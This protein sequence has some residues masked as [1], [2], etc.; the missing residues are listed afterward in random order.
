ML[1][2]RITEPDGETHP[3][4][5]RD[6]I[7]ATLN[8]T[9]R[10]AGAAGWA[11]LGA[12]AIL[13]GWPAAE[14]LSLQGLEVEWTIGP[15]E[16]GVLFLF[17]GLLY[18]G[19]LGI[20]L[21]RRGHADWRRAAGFALLAMFWFAFGWNAG[22]IIL[23]GNFELPDPL[24]GF[25]IWFIGFLAA[26]VWMTLAGLLFLPVLRSRTTVTWPLGAGAGFAA[27]AGAVA[28]LDLIGVVEALQIVV[29]GWCAV[30]AAALS[31]AL[32]Q[33][34]RAGGGRAGSAGRAGP[35]TRHPE[36]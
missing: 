36:S 27:L 14:W 9:P 23:S 1:Y 8:R 32:P 11:L 13:L 25:L 26:T 19:M 29:A 22:L 31:L 16:I 30:Y 28:I 15:V 33:A 17:I 18:S 21:W 20:A 35:R 4:R 6:K 3:V 5:A 24:G 34:P 10:L 12:A 2:S 7:F